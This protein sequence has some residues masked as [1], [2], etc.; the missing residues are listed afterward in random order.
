MKGNVPS[1]KK[2][3]IGVK[4]PLLAYLRKHNRTA[5]LPMQYHDLL[6]YESSIPL[7]DQAGHD[8]LWET[9][10]YSQS[11]FEDVNQA[12]K[13]IYALLKTDGDVEVLD[14]LTVAR[15]DYCTF[16]N[17]KPFRVRIINRLNDNYDHFYVKKADASRIYGLE[18]EGLLS[19][20]H[21]TYLIDGGTLIEEHVVGI[22]GDDFMKRNLEETTFNQIRIAKEFIKFNERCFVRLLGDMRAYNYVIAITPD[23]EG[24]QYRMRPIDFDQQSYEGRKGFYLPQYFRENDPIIYLGMQHMTAETVKQYQMEE[25]SLIAGRVKASQKHFKALMDVMVRDEI[26]TTDKIMELA[27]GL[28]HHHKNARFE[29][30]RTM[31]EVVLT[32]IQLLL[33][34]DFKQSILLGKKH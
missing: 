34:K 6:R 14:H 5:V 33:E 1:K 24:S 7:H 31:G 20:N 18:L 16:G 4:A 9:V 3:M 12:M 15:I 17:T 23:I 32:N 30:C 22:P 27:E 2:A 26:S 19:P 21:V 29:E 11:D 13:L 28:A 25:R 10:Y 8:T